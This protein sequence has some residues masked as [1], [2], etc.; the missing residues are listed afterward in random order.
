VSNRLPDVRAIAVESLEHLPQC[1][2]HAR[3]YFS[4]LLAWHGPEHLNAGQS[5]AIKELVDCGLIYFCAWGENC[6][7]VHDAVDHCD[8]HRLQKVDHIIM[9]TW[10]KDETLE[11]A[12]FFFQ[13]CVC[14]AEPLQDMPYDRFA[15]SVGRPDWYQRMAQYFSPK[16]SRS[17]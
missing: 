13:D 3:Q 8:I 15:V 2:P 12:M 11:E 4:L 16:S 17:S 14:P 10:H 5:V 7:S 6:E 9:T 1:L